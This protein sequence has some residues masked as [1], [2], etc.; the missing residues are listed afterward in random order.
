MESCIVGVKKWGAD[1]MLVPLWICALR[2]G[3]SYL[4]QVGN[5]C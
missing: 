4:E 2:G 5:Y 1:A 3:I